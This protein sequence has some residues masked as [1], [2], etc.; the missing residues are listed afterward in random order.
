MNAFVR[1][2]K[3][4]F[5]PIDEIDLSHTI[6]PYN[7]AVV[8]E[9]AQ[10]IRAIGLQTPLT[11]IVR[12]GQH[13]LVSGRNRLEAL[14]V[15]GC[16]QAP[17][18]IVD[19]DDVEAQLWRLSEN[20]HRAELTKLEYDRQVVRY[21]ELLKVKQVAGDATSLR[22]QPANEIPAGGISRQL[23]EKVSQRAIVKP[24][25]RPE[26]GNSAVARA[27]NVA[28]ATVR[29]AYQ[30]ASLSPEAQEAAAATGLDDNRSALLEAAKERTPEAQAA[31]I[32][33]L[34]EQKT[35]PAEP[36]SESPRRSASVAPLRDLV[37]I[38]GGELARWIKITT[39]NDRP[40]VIRV[41]EMAAGIL[42]DELEAGPASRPLGAAPARSEGARH[43]HAEDPDNAKEGV[44]AHCARK[45]GRAPGFRMSEEHRSKIK[46]SSILRA[47]IEYFE[48][49]R[50]MSATQVSVGLRLLKKVLPDLPPLKGSGARRRGSARTWLAPSAGPHAGDR[51]DRSRVLQHVH[52][53][54]GGEAIVGNV[55][56]SAEGARKKSEN[57]SHALGYA[58]GVEMPR[59]IEADRS[60]L[61]S[62]GRAGP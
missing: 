38:S 49:K 12:D 59:Q 5:L 20:L 11:C 24:A 39:P 50:E 14:R 46:N 3:H 56:A 23:D 25:G 47:L 42:R 19:F 32:R 29:R 44:V 51:D 22:A 53:A 55:N 48:G 2:A 13:V 60:A 31:T 8:A 6:R 30:T 33:R 41:L 27:L 35:A 57:Q 10:S 54:E 58:P 61:P 4:T 36:I 45:R 7:A 18:R 16:E 21:A 9:L 1:P 62:A 28:E 52:V 37:G 40:H 43:E 26:G 34:A 17:V 15:I